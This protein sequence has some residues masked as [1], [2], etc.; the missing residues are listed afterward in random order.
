MSRF[1]ELLTMK[2]KNKNNI[3]KN[4]QNDSLSELMDLYSSLKVSKEYLQ[5]FNN[6]LLLLDKTYQSGFITNEIFKIRKIKNLIQKLNK[7][8]STREKLISLLLKYD[9]YLTLHITDDIHNDT[10][11]EL[12]DVLSDIRIV[13][14]NIILGFL[15]IKKTIALDCLRG[16]F[17]IENIITNEREYLNKM[18]CDLYFLKNSTIGNFFNINENIDTFLSNLKMEIPYDENISMLIKKCEYFLIKKNIE[19]EMEEIR[20]E[21]EKMEKL[22]KNDLDIIEEKKEDND[23]INKKEKEMEEKVK[24]DININQNHKQNKE[25][26]N[27]EKKENKKIIEKIP[28]NNK[29]Q[30]EYIIGSLKQID[31]IYSKYYTSIPDD[32][33]NSFNISKNYNDYIKGIFPHIIIIKDNSKQIKGISFINFIESYKLFISNFST[34]TIEDYK[35]ILNDF[36]DFLKNNY[37]FEELFLDFY[38]NHIDGK[39]IQNKDLEKILTKEIKFKWVNMENDGTIRKIKYKLINPNFKEKKRNEGDIIKIKDMAYIQFKNIQG[40]NATNMND[41]DLDKTKG[42]INMNSIIKGEEEINIFPLFSLFCEMMYNGE[43][44]VESQSMEYMNMEVMKDISEDLI[45][46]FIKIDKDTFIK[47]INEEYSKIKIEKEKIGSKLISDKENF[48]CGSIFDMSISFENMISTKINNKIYNKIWYIE[49]NSFIQKLELKETEEIFYLLPTKNEKISVMIYEENKQNKKSQLNNY[50][51]KD[52]ENEMTLFQYMNKIYQDIIPIE[53]ENKK[54]IFIPPFS[55][56]KFINFD[57]PKLLDEFTVDNM[58]QNSYRI[59]NFSQLSQF[60]FD[61][62]KSKNLL[63]IKL[64]EKDDIIIK[65]NFI[66][67]II[68]Y[69]ALNELEVPTIMTFLVNNK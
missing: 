24:E 32:L 40:E 5:C 62:D 39:F 12:K 2:G 1:K 35:D 20:K 16:K 47:Y 8:I 4:S 54:G 13:S 22:K 38:Y 3:N 46:N 14:I 43:Y 55:N 42:I 45:K 33:K 53:N 17:S 50:F 21:K 26:K 37:I 36:I 10:I 69:D 59:Q 23:S 58:E 29:Y 66:M 57:N 25:N 63:E 52:K 27:E 60:V 7:N 44:G 64:N 11:K 51:E 19:I 6:V 34:N 31:E 18:K 56:S 48:N 15:K 67:A 65:N 30:Y 68:N 49:D 41:S 9:K 28:Q 61:E